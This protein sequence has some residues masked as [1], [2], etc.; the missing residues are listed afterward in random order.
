MSAHAVSAPVAVGRRPGVATVLRWELRKL[1]AQKRTFLGLG[2]AIVVPVIFV[3]ALLADPGGGG[4]DEVAFGSFVRET[5]LAIPL[6][7]LAFGSIWLIPLVTALVAGGT[8][9]TA[10][11]ERAL[12]NTPPP[13]AA[14]RRCRP[15]RARRP[16]R[17]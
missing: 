11:Q 7:C 3:V 10:G 5:G 2:A 8:L 4:P 14:R 16:S 6:V 15:R 1:L 17:T 9:A 12:L 13:P